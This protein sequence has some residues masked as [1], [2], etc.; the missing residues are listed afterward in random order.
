MEDLLKKTPKGYKYSS[1][2]AAV[3]IVCFFLPW[4]LVSCG[5]QQIKFSG[6]ELS[7]GTD[8]SNG[9][10]YQHMSGDPIFFFILFAALGA[11]VLAYL[12]IQRGILK[13]QIDDYVLLGLGISPLIILLIKISSISQASQQGAS[14]EYQF[15]FWGTIIGFAGIIYGGYINYKELNSTVPK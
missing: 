12:S 11:L 8:I 14:I 3:A 15:G 9:L 13:K 6:W 4:I 2:G 5:G 1:S 7:A 10:Y